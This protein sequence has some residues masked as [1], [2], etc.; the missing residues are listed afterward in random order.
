MK[1]IIVR[2]VF[3]VALCV[4]VYSGFNLGSVY[5]KYWKVNKDNK[6][7][8]QKVITHAKKPKKVQKK[9]V[10]KRHIAGMDQNALK[11]TIDF[12]QLKSI[13]SDIIGW[14]YIPHTVVDYAVLKGQDN[15]T[16]LHHNYYKKYS[17]AG[18]I[19]MDQMNKADFTDDNTILYGHNM[20][21]GSMFA[22]LKQYMSQ[23]YM[24]KHP[25]I[26]VYR[27]DGSLNVY[28][29]FSTNIFK[30]VSHMYAKG[31]PYESYVKKILSTSL[32]KEDVEMKAAPLLMCSTCSGAN[33]ENRNVVYGRLAEILH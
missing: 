17:F 10:R 31:N 28:S 7:L 14:I 8:A 3:I 32:A 1:K 11:R 6:D 21:N 13:N 23:S 24:D 25:Y 26:Y 27:P 18:C 29:V 2:I 33:S 9:Y 30:A 12:K 16:Y 19:F 4:F 22:T 5:Y 15:N 20:K